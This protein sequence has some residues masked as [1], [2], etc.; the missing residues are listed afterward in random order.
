MNL[1]GEFRT[2][3]FKRYVQSSLTKV[4]L[5][6]FEIQSKNKRRIKWNNGGNTQKGNISK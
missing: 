1:M 6:R 4:Y 3:I 5:K 2:Q